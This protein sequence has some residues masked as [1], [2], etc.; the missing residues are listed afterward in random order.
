MATRRGGSH[1]QGCLVTSLPYFSHLAS[2]ANLL[3]TS[4][5]AHQLVMSLIKDNTKEI[6][7]YFKEK[8]HNMLPC[9]SS[10]AHFV[11]I[12]PVEDPGLTVLSL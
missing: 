4:S 3:G 10:L 9:S 12:S 6:L 7:Q 2:P 11:N 1:F 8:L 5:Q